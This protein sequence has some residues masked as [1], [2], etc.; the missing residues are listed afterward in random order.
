MKENTLVPDDHREYLAKAYNV[1]EVRKVLSL[2][3]LKEL[4]WTVNQYNG[5]VKYPSLKRLYVLL[6]FHIQDER[7]NLN[8]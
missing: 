8:K 5:D 1:E 7:G 2:G 6:E 4:K 3:K